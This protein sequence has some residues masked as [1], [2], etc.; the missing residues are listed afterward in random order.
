MQRGDAK[1][2]SRRCHPLKPPESPPVVGRRL[3]LSGAAE[4]HPHRGHCGSGDRIPPK[5]AQVCRRRRRGEGVAAAD[6][7][8][9][10]IATT[11]KWEASQRLADERVIALPCARPFATSVTRAPRTSSPRRHRTAAGSRHWVV[12]RRMLGSPRVDLLLVV[13]TPGLTE[14]RKGLAPTKPVPGVVGRGVRARGHAVG[15]CM[16]ATYAGIH[17]PTLLC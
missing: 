15:A 9:K 13:Q 11:F 5:A 12:G 16:P 17:E 10:R 6:A 2:S 4:L 7:I 3:C 8:D 1:S 14:R